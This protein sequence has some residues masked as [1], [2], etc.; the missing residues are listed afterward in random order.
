MTDPHLLAAVAAA[1]RRELSESETTAVDHLA[2]GAHALVRGHLGQEPPPEADSTVAYVVA[3]MI[4]RALSRTG[5]MPVGLATMSTTSGPFSV[6]QGFSTDAQGG[7][8]WLTRQDQIMLSP[9]CRSVV[10]VPLASE[11]TP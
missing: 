4:A 3:Q 9:W 8:V 1:L 11:R 6:S 5:D 2:V 10:C 7:G